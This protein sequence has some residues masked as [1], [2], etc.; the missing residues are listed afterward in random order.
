MILD[1]EK[2]LMEDLKNTVNWP[3]LIEEQFNGHA[4]NTSYKAYVSS[5]YQLIKL[6]NNTCKI[7]DGMWFAIKSNEIIF[8]QFDLMSDELLKF[9][10]I[11]SP[12]GNY[13]KVVLS[14]RGDILKKYNVNNECLQ[15][16][17]DLL[18]SQPGYKIISNDSHRIIYSKF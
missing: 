2:I 16:I 10:Y 17:V 1:D 9:E 11:I 4:T 7:A 12:V 6:L 15:N 5:L 8:A 18:A 14:T 13:L 3:S